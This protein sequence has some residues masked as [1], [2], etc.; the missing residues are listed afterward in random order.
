MID[1]STVGCVSCF[2][3]C[4]HYMHALQHTHTHTHTHIM[5]CVDV[6]D[7]C[8]MYMYVGWSVHGPTNNEW[9]LLAQLQG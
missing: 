8:M 3:T 7:T 9:S 6:H 5:F 4:T 2:G 1:S